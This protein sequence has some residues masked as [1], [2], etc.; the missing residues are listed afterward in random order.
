MGV[1]I[2]R[3]YLF[4]MIIYDFFFREIFFIGVNNLGR[5]C[6]FLVCFLLVRYGRSWYIIKF[7]F[8]LVY[9]ICYG[10]IVRELVV[11]KKN[12]LVGMVLEM[13]EFYGGN[14]N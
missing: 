2:W 9:Y 1:F 10:E 7:F 8:S 3:I 12:S 6:I 5:G 11:V 13:F 4:F 14:Y